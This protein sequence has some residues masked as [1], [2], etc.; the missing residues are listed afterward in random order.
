[1]EVKI[2]VGYKNG[3]PIS[4]NAGNLLS[5][6][7]STLK[8][9]PMRTGSLILGCYKKRGILGILVLFEPKEGYFW[10]F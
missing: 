4:F 5:S 1:M 2:K 8:Q 6:T 9:M 7:R 3:A 10:I